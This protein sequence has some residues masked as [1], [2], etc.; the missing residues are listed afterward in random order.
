MGNRYTYPF[1]LRNMRKRIL[2][3][4]GKLSL[5]QEKFA[6][7]IGMSKSNFNRLLNQENLTSETL[8][9]LAKH[10]K[11]EPQWF[12]VSDT[13]AIEKMKDYEVFNF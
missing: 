12:F 3:R 1:E 11:V 10:L 4:L 2:H 7:K 6:N 9:V 5:T 13:K 8:I